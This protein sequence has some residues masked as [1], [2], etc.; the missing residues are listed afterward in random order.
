M[1]HVTSIASHPNLSKILFK[2]HYAIIANILF[3]LLVL[4]LSRPTQPIFLPLVF[5]LV[6]SALI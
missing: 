2:R 3:I 1:P 4:A 6:L 5:L